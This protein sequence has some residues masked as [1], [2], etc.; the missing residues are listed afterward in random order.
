[1]NDNNYQNLTNCQKNEFFEATQ[2][3]IILPYKDA[4]SIFYKAISINEKLAKAWENF[5][6][7]RDS[8]LIDFT[9][10]S[11]LMI[12]VSI[13]K[14]D[15]EMHFFTLNGETKKFAIETY[16]ISNYTFSTLNEE[17]YSYPSCNKECLRAF[18]K[19][20]D[21]NKVLISYNEKYKKIEDIWNNIELSFR[22]CKAPDYLNSFMFFKEFFPIPESCIDREIC[23]GRFIEQR[24]SEYTHLA[25]IDLLEKPKKIKNAYNKK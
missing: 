19:D 3:N 14:L 12:N 16:K 8:T 11:D 23:V 9:Q 5:I 17:F 18:V 6:N 20:R 7:Y 25:S 1:M 10:P 13:D 22:Y 21:Y 4:L 24:K 15:G 2:K